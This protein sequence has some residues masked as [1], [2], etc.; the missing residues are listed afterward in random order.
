VEI[1]VARYL[2]KRRKNISIGQILV[3]T[4]YWWKLR[5]R[6]IKRRKIIGIAK[7]LVSTK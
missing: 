7:I 5:W 1:K 4:K 3:L 6:V 2:I